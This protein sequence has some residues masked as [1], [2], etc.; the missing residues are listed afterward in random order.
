MTQ[1]K[2]SGEDIPHI[3]DLLAAGAGKAQGSVHDMGEAL[4][5]AGL[6]A[7]QT[8]LSIEETTG[9]LAAFA[10]A[11]LT[12]S[13]AGTSFKTMLAAMTPNSKEAAKAMEEL[14]LSAF[15]ANG[16]FIGLS[17]YAGVLQSSLSKMTDEQRI[18][19]METIFG[20]DAILIARSRSSLLI[21]AGPVP[22]SRS[23]TSPTRTPCPAGAALG[24]YNP[25]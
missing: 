19:T 16:E 18:A 1:F 3:A 6:V 17:E 22:K 21:C 24:T 4:N 23:A 12:G 15:D 5:Q 2:L 7:S 14:G 20:S 8:G 9:G 25:S 13:D 11:G 10:S